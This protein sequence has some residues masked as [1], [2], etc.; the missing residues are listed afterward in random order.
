[1]LA[2]SATLAL[3]SPGNGQAPVTLPMYLL[4]QDV[5]GRWTFALDVSS[6]RDKF[7]AFLR[8]S[9]ELEVAMKDVRLLL[10]GLSMDA[11]AIAGQA[12]ALSQ[13]H[14]VEGGGRLEVGPGGAPTEAAAP[15][16][17]LPASAPPSSLQPLRPIHPTPRNALCP[18]QTHGFCHRCGAPTV[19]VEAG[20]R[21]R[22]TGS[23]GHKTYPRT[24]PVVI[25]LVE[26]PDGQR[27]LLGRSARSTPGMYTCL[28][29][30][31]DQ[32]EGIE[33]AVRREV[34][35]EARIAVSDVTILGTQPWPIGRYG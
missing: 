17:L 20:T 31:I 32:C 21:R 27:A 34:M 5:S 24:D 6:A 26:S 28:S 16:I 35:E 25:A 18:S 9:C 11:A 13:W 7:L 29:G 14:Q 30:F 10:P 12:V 3:P 4:G 8:D 33:E 23:G 15:G 22:C 1:M 19:P 2:H